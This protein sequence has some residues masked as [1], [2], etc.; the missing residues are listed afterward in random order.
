MD[1]YNSELGDALRQCEESKARAIRS[2]VTLEELKSAVAR[3]RSKVENQAFP[4]PTDEELP[5]YLRELDLKLTA[6]M[7]AVSEALN[8]DDR[9]SSA[10]TPTASAPTAAR[11]RCCHSP[12][13]SRTSSRK[14]SATR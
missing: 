5:E 2:S 12:S 4:P 8:Q 9:S 3:F 7:K 1:K 14:C 10:P 11:T 6:K 13:C